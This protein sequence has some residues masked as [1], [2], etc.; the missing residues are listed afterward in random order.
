M[1]KHEPSIP[2]QF[3]SAVE[4]VLNN[5]DAPNRFDRSMLDAYGKDC[6]DWIESIYQSNHFAWTA[7][8]RS[9]WSSFLRGYLPT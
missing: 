7:E 3:V 4:Y 5:R 1:L 8:E 6:M 2:S 9:W